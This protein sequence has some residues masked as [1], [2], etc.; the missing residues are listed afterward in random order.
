[1]PELTLLMSDEIASECSAS[2]MSFDR[3][4]DANVDQV[5]Q[6]ERVPAPHEPRPFGAGRARQGGGDALQVEPP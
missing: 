3:D 4:R 1:M 2:I 6:D 5:C